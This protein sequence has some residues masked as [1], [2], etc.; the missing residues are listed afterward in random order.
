[1]RAGMIILGLGLVVLWIVA[2]GA[3]A[4]G[5]LTWLDLIAALLAFAAAGFTSLGRAAKSRGLDLVGPFGLAVGL[6]ILW[7]VGLATG[8]TLWLTW[9][10][11]AF[12]IGFGL[13]GAGVGSTAMERRR[14]VSGPRAV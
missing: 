12:G 2:L 4:T 5:W 7:I 13:L 11:F 3:H 8:A 14:P 10:T 6:L 1:M 9:W